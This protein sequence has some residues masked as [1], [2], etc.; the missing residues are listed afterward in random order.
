MFTFCGRVAII[1]TMYSHYGNIIFPYR[2]TKLAMAALDWEH[3]T[4]GK[5]TNSS[6]IQLC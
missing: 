2:E 6:L 3:D 4:V 1:A 5:V